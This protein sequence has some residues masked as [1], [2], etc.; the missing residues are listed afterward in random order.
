MV[1]PVS[2]IFKSFTRK[3]KGKTRIPKLRGEIDTEMLRFAYE[4]LIQHKKESIE[5][6]KMA[7]GMLIARVENRK[8]WLPNVTD[9]INKLEDSLSKVKNKTDT[10]T[11]ELQQSGKSQEEIE[12]DPDYIRYQTAYNE[13]QSRLDEKNE[14]FS[15][16]QQDIKKAEDRIE[17]FK[18][19]IQR[20]HRKIAK[21]QEEQSDTIQD[22]LSKIK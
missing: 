21:I 15:K 6:Y 3:F 7:I 5:H 13:I 2:A 8:S 18:H 4:V 22:H 20:L 16:L 19:Q 1:K 14:R 12:Q 10:L 9:D 11:V 17:H